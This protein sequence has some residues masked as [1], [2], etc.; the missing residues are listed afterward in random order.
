MVVREYNTVVYLRLTLY[1]WQTEARLLTS[2]NVTILSVK[3]YLL[4]LTAQEGR[5][6][7]V[8]PFAK[9]NKMLQN[10]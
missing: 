8:G 1:K 7:I 2:L 4:A 9:E 3:G 6:N 10:L 5:K